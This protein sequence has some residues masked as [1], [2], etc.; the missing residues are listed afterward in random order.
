VAEVRLRREELRLGALPAVCVRTGR[1]ADGTIEVTFGWLPPWTFLLL[2]AGIVP[3][4]VAALLLRERIP[5]ELPVTRQVVE[6]YHG[7]ARPWWLGWAVVVVALGVRSWLGRPAGLV[8]LG[9]G[10]GLV[11][12]GLVRRS[13]G[14]VTAVPVRGTPFVELRR[15]H[16]AFAAAVASRRGSPAA[17]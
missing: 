13:N 14:W 5:G 1:P 7:T 12:L 2:L 6:R 11:A 8:A 10:L 4:F 16:P 17:G 15:V 9:V 3:F